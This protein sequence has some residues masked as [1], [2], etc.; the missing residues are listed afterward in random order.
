MRRTLAAFGTAVALLVAGVG[1]AGQEGT[2]PVASG[3]PVSEV[4]VGLTEWSITV[5][6]QALAPGTVTIRVTNVGA[7]AHDL[8]VRGRR[9]TW[10]TPVLRP[11]EKALL[12]VQTGAGEDL[13]LD[14]TVTGHHAAG[15]HG[16]LPVA[17][18]P[19]S[20]PSEQMHTSTGGPNHG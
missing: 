19:Q 16:A 1:C 6:E 15:M 9:G 13:H 12:T 5:P 14:C 3:E 10:R 7:A 20:D 4:R 11:G 8:S 18:F 17:A 2:R